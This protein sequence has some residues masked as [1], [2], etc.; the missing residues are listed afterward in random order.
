MKTWRNPLK[1]V[2]YISKTKMMRTITTL[3]GLMMFV[4]SSPCHAQNS[5]GSCDLFEDGPNDAWPRV[6]TSTTSED[7]SSGDV[8]TLELNVTSL[9]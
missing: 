4:L 5:I 3:F 8:Q 1:S 7:P 6:I 9:P 2:S